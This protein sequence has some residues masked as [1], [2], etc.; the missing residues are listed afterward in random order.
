[1]TRD[2]AFEADFFTDRP[3]DFILS[4]T[5]SA[6]DL[7]L[8]FARVLGFAF[9]SEA[10]ATLLVA[11]RAPRAVLSI[12]AFTLFLIIFAMHRG[13]ASHGPVRDY[14][15]IKDD[16]AGAFASNVAA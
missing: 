9:A 1:L 13:C 6:A 14:G 8:F 15:A 16:H 10:S 3:A 12:P 5:R 11:L 2:L 7:I 4:P